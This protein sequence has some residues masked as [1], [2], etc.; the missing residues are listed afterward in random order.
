MAPDFATL[1]DTCRQFVAEQAIRLL[2]LP[3][4]DRAQTSFVVAI[5]QTIPRA[6]MREMEAWGDSF[7][8]WISKSNPLASMN[9]T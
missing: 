1:S 8:K 3:G 2:G 4:I 9:D 7:S 6:F 5:V